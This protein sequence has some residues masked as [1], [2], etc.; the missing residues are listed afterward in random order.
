MLRQETNTDG[1]FQAKE[2]IQTGSKTIK[3]SWKNRKKNDEASKGEKEKYPPC[4]HCKKTSYPHWRCWWRPEVVYRSCNQKGHVEK[5]CKKKQQGAQ[6]AQEFEDEKEEH[7]FVATCFAK[8]VISETWLIDNGCT[9]HMSHDR[10]IF[11]KLDDTHHSK[12]KIRNGNYMR[13]KA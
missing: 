8:N 10:D 2:K 12:V 3:K 6:I 4:Q 7:M 13:L 1:A 9:H 11:V 5:A